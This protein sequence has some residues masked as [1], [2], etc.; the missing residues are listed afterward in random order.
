MIIHH[1]NNVATFVGNHVWFS[2]FGQMFLHNRVSATSA[3]VA[4]AIFPHDTDIAGI[5]AADTNIAG[6]G[7]RNTNVSGIGPGASGLAPATS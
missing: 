7:P 5:G 1:Q 6:I 3:T 4:G 2:F